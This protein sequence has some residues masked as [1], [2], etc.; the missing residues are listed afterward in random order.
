MASYIDYK[1]ASIIGKALF[2]FSQGLDI[3]EHRYKGSI[4]LSVSDPFTFT[5]S[6]NLGANDY[7]YT[8]LPLAIRPWTA[9]Q[10]EDVN[11]IATGFSQIAGMS[12]ERTLSYSK[13]N[14]AQIGT[15][16]D[17]NISLR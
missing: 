8:Q 14:P 9:S 13:L 15:S 10:I 12:F 4:K 1:P 3:P 6:S 11:A 7:V 2:N 5:Q 17:I 16:S